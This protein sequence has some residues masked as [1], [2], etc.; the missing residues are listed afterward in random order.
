MSARRISANRRQWLE[1]R[2]SERDRQL[3]DWVA[4]LRLATGQQ[5]EQLAFDDLS[6]S[7]LPVV[8]GRVLRRLVDWNLLELVDR[9]VG[10]S[11]KGSASGIYRLTAAGHAIA[12]PAAAR[13]SRPYTD[14]FTAHTIATSQLAADLVLALRRHPDYQLD[15]FVTEPASWMP[16]GLG[17]YLKPDAY[18]RLQS[19]SLTMH[20][21]VEIDLGSESLPALERKL[22]NYLG[23]VARGLG[24][25][26]GT[27]PRVV[28]V[29]TSDGRLE[30][31][32]TL[33]RRL[34]YPATELFTICL[35]GRAVV[36]LLAAFDE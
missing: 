33:L 8:R 18:L 21:W 31:V 3:L 34:P 9:R 17:S 16:D 22:R 35:S 14:R 5:L 36:T 23:F 4:R 29:V 20:W 15:T 24:G 28:L 6:P 26:S 27:V 19:A 12:L 11:A 7:S 2:L 13:P 30:A 25:P 32:T 1:S 10:G